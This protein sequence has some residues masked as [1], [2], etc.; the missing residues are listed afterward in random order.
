MEAEQSLCGRLI[1]VIPSV[2]IKD[3]IVGGPLVI[4]NAASHLAGYITRADCE[5]K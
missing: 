2:P 1:H 4:L 5:A 3:L